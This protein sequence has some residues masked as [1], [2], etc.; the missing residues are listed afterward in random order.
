MNQT[1]QIHPVKCREAAIS[2]PAKLFNGASFFFFGFWTSER[3]W[4][5]RTKK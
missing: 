5:W 1:N 4:F 3:G 2:L